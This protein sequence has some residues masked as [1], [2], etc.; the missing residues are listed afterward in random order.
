MK[1][2]TKTHNMTTG[3]RLRRMIVPVISCLAL[4]NCSAE[5]PF[6]KEDLQTELLAAINDL[7]VT[8]CMCNGDFMPPV[9]TLTWNDTL[10]KTADS[11]A[12]DMYMNGY[13]SH[14]SPDGTP[15]ILRAMQAGYEGEYVGEN[16]ARNYRS[17]QDVVQGWKESESHCK[18]MM[19]TLYNE[20]G[21]SHIGGYWVLDLGRSK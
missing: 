8:G 19:D 6:K 9:N 12:R 4:W 3:V 7:R 1:T 5:E 21:A 17:I 20:M 14:L 16:I 10:Q 18:T 13:F 15:P 11:H 2:S